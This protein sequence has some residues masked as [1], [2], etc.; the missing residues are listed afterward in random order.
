[1]TANP[2][3]QAARDALREPASAGDLVRALGKSQPTVSRLLQQM[4][5]E[6]VALGRGRR[7]RYALKAPILGLPSHQ[8]LWWTDEKG[9]IERC[10]ELDF[11]AGDRL[12]VELPGL[13]LSTQGTL[14]WFLAPLR[15]QGFLGRIRAH[16]L[17]P[18]GFDR[19]PDRWTIAQQLYAIVRHQADPAGAITVGEPVAATPTIVS[20]RSAQRLREFDRLAQDVSLTLPAG[21]SAAGEQPKFLAHITG[22]PR[23][24]AS[25]HLLIKFAPPAGTPFGDR[26]HDLLHAEA[27]A[28]QVLAAHGVA[29]ARARVEHTPTRAMLVSERFDRIG[30][31]GRRHVVALDAIHDAFV[32]GP[33]Q[34]WA[35]TCDVLARQRR[36]SEDDAATVR[37]LLAFGRLIG[38]SDMHFGNLGF[39]VTRAGLANGRLTLAPVYDMLPMHWRPDP[40]TG[41]LDLSPFDPAGHDLA[42]P[43][44]AW[45][46]A[47]WNALAST[48]EVSVK[49]RSLARD[50]GKRVRARPLR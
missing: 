15:A 47:F 38:N 14:P 31:R 12:H 8:P 44:R 20:N 45:A 39:F 26:W 25:M 49:F 5:D 2:D 35:V 46:E 34:H 7:R 16:A 21:S 36:I 32:A 22:E 4:S 28:L 11:L 33:R 23:N 27:V 17:S 42:S 3:R 10:G 6:V 40:T 41:T 29:A 1:M 50:M 19:D 43:A 13:S 24:D 9:R 18:L 37:K 48:S 30:S